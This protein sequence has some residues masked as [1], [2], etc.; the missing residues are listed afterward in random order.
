MCLFHDYN[1]KHSKKFARY[2]D[3]SNIPQTRVDS[4]PSNG[5]HYG[6]EV[7]GNSPTYDA[8]TDSVDLAF[9]SFED[10]TYSKLDSLGG[11]SVSDVSSLP[12]KQPIDADARGAEAHD[13]EAVEFDNPMYTKEQQNKATIREVDTVLQGNMVQPDLTRELSSAWEQP[14]FDYCCCLLYSF[15]CW[16]NLV[17]GSLL[18]IVRCT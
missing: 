17:A 10:P 9:S 12:R 11:A 16:T 6:Q 13:I 7:N 18:R 5:F 3:S 15:L 4:T 8:R 2:R 14:L 1:R